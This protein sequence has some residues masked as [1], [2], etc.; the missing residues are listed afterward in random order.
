MSIRCTRPGPVVMLLLLLVG[1]ALVRP[2]PARAQSDSPFPQVDVGGVLAKV[3]ERM[4][5]T[6]DRA[7]SDWRRW[8]PRLPGQTG[9]HPRG[10]AV[11]ADD[12]G[13]VLVGYQAGVLKIVAR[14]GRTVLFI[15]QKE[16]SSLQG[17]DSVEFAPLSEQHRQGIFRAMEIGQ[18]ELGAVAHG[19][20][21]GFRSLPATKAVAILG[22]LASTPDMRFP[23]RAGGRVRTFLSALLRSERDPKVRRM[24]VLSLALADRTDEAT[25]TAVLDFMEASHNAWETFTTQ[26]Y[27]EYH[28]GFVR[29]L[30]SSGHIRRRLA[31]SGNPYGPIIAGNL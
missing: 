18:Q 29:G 3:K 28:C 30:P 31:R 7:P 5:Q 14:D 9:E 17:V 20:M 26:Q 13:R 10:R 25:V 12:L 22:V 4:R 23:E 19:L 6:V 27:F 2:L 1:L 15:K 11:S 16:G 24:A 21:N 8:I